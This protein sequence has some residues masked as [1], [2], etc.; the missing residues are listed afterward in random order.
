MNKIITNKFTLLGIAVLSVFIANTAFAFSDNSS[1]SDPNPPYVSTANTGS[2]MNLYNTSPY[3]NNYGMY[4]NS[5]N[6]NGAGNNTGYNNYNTVPNNTTYGSSTTLNDANQNDTVSV[7]TKSNT[8]TKVATANT[9]K[10]TTKTVA[11]NNTTNTTSTMNTSNTNNANSNQTASVADAFFG[12]TSNT[13]NNTGYGLP[14]L[15]WFGSPG[16]FPNTIFEWVLTFFFIIVLLLLTR[17]FIPKH[18]HV[19]HGTVAV[20]H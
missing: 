1:F 3:P 20:H 19:A 9:T 8:S 18:G 7:S 14:A 6:Y 17:Q 2:I 11:T 5:N 10:S 16:F 13:N 12:T 15:S 4:N